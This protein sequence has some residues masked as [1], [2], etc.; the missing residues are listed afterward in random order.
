M[1]RKKFAK[2]LG[3][4]TS[5]M[6]SAKNIFKAAS[7]T[8]RRRQ[9]QRRHESPTVKHGTSRVASLAAKFGLFR[10]TRLNRAFKLFEK[11]HSICKDYKPVVNKLHRR[12]PFQDEPCAR[13]IVLATVLI[14]LIVDLCCFV[15]S[16]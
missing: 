16:H 4:S 11:G 12:G 6:I 1:L 5:D 8:G 7:T 13:G 10:S 3:L 2:G 15:R 9:R 14:V